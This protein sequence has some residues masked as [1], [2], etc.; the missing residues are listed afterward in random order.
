M[1]FDRAGWSP[2]DASDV[3]GGSGAAPG[4]RTLTS[5][6]QGKAVDASGDVANFQGLAGTTVGGQQ[7]AVAPSAPP[8]AGESFLDSLGV[9]P[10][11][12]QIGALAPAEQG[13]AARVAAPPGLAAQAD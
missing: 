11:V 9:Q 6:L 5:A 2:E 4:K 8:S 13:R 12:A 3:V 10:V 1:S 7:A